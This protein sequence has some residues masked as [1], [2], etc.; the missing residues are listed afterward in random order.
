LED[1]D[2]PGVVGCP[3]SQREHAGV[4]LRYNIMTV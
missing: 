3:F 1:V 2:E 4:E